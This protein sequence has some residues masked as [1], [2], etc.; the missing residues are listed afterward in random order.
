MKCA[1]GIH[2]MRNS[3][4]RTVIDACLQHPSVRQHQAARKSWES[5]CN[6]WWEGFRSMCLFA[7]NP[8]W[9]SRADLGRLR[10]H[11]IAVA[12]N[13]IQWGKLL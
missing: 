6:T 12:H 1:A 11:S 10:R 2:F 13:Y 9:V 7:W 8:A 4:W 3:V 5:V